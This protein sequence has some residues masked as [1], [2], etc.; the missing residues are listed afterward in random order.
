E[1]KPPHAMLDAVTR[2]QHDDRDRIRLLADL[3]EDVPAVEARQH[4]V[5]NEK[6]VLAREREL[7]TVR[8]VQARVDGEPF[9]VEPVLQR[10]GG[11][12]VVFDN[13]KVHGGGS[14]HA[15][16]ARPTLKKGTAATLNAPE[17]RLRS[18]RTIAHAKN[19]HKQRSRNYKNVKNHAT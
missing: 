14:R 8:A 18:S 2:S 1:R 17:H 19:R 6:V 3:F 10:L 15:W 9:G 4:H 7:E 13:E 16:V 5:Q 12:G 11:L